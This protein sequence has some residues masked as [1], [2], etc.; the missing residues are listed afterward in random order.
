MHLIEPLGLLRG[1]AACEA[2]QRRLALPLA[3]GPAAFSLA[4]LIGAAPG[5]NPGEIVPAGAVPAAFAP[6]LARVC[7]APPPWA[8]LAGG[9]PWVMGILNVTPDSFSDGGRHADPGAA[10]AAGLAMHAA[11]ADLVDIGGESTRPGSLP[12]APD[13]EQRRILPVIRTLAA[14][15]VAVSVDTRHAATM[16][17][18]LAA[19]ARVI[20]D[21]SALAHDAAA[22]GVVAAA[23]AP[24]VLMHMRGT[25]Q[26]MAAHASYAD[27]A[28][29]VVR[30]LAARLAAAEA[31]GIARADIAVDPGIGFAKND[32]GNLELLDRLAILHNLGCHV[33]AGVSRKRFI[34]HLSGE[35]EPALRGP[36]SLA[37]ALAALERGASILRVHDVPETVQAVRVWRGLHP[38]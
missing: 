27:I 12:L 29:E 19:G 15:G 23:R 37:A 38:R 32:H 4:R 31:A 30:E 6:A 1:S 28:A 26:T 2:I 5:D 20:N 7:A 22:A 14:A 33:L 11:G 17:A 24:V 10:T 16:R 34:G 9:G 3:G 21:I 35:A 18:A 13:E 25:P 36:G 8:G